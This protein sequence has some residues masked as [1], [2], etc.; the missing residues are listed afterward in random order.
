MTVHESWKCVK[1]NCILKRKRLLFLPPMPGIQSLFGF[2][3]CH[4]SGAIGLRGGL[5]HSGYGYKLFGLMHRVIRV[6]WFFF[7]LNIIGF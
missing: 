5:R 1:I 7:S 4:A 3:P 2:L 6:I